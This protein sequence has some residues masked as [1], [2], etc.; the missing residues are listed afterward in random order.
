MPAQLAAFAS[1]RGANLARVESLGPE[2][3]RRTGLHPERGPVT[4]LELVRRMAA[5]DLSHLRQIER[6]RSDLGA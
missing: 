5:H 6:A 2:A 4:L 3:W 1:A